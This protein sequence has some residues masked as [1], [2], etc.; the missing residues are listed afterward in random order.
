MPRL[1]VVLVSV[2]EGRVGAA[3]ADWFAGRARGHGGFEVELMDLKAV[4]LPL[5]REANHPR[6]QK[7]TEPKTIEW[8]RAVSELDAF[9]FVSPE[10][11]FSTPPSLVNALDHLYHEWSYKAAGL[12]TYGGV[13]GGLRAAQMT[14]LMLTTFKMVPL[15]EA[16]S[17]PFV[18]KLL[19]E[20]R[21]TGGESYDRAAH[22]MLDELLRWT[23]ALAALRT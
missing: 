23:N 6:L 11:N 22:G 15:V 14:R 17:I 4:D 20:G 2:R 13:S 19:E 16:V 9:V 12:V 21:F 18:S 10:Y 8:S 7:Y 3:V 5:L 1:G